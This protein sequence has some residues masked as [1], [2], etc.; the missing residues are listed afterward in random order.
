MALHQQ[1]NSI[2]APLMFPSYVCRK[3]SLKLDVHIVIF[4]MLLCYISS[5]L[6]IYLACVLKVLCMR[7]L[8]LNL[9]IWL[10][11]INYLY[12]AGIFFVCL[13]LN[14][15]WYLELLMVNEFFEALFEIITKTITCN[16]VLLNNFGPMPQPF[17]NT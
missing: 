17:Y 11:A 1:G 10:C 15:V 7:I 12:F 3:C 9:S 14:A 8:L 5:I 4:L 13:C 16:S 6:C 2:S